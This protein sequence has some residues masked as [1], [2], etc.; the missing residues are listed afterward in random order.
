[1]LP[2]E[3]WLTLLRCNVK[4]T[5]DR[6]NYHVRQLC[7]ELK[8]ANLPYRWN[9]VMLKRL[10]AIHEKNVEQLEA[11]ATNAWN[12]A[13]PEINFPTETKGRERSDAHVMSIGDDF[14]TTLDTMSLE[15]EPPSSVPD[16]N[17]S[18]TA[19]E[20]DITSREVEITHSPRTWDRA[21]LHVTLQHRRR[22]KKKK[23]PKAKI[24]WQRSRGKQTKILSDYIQKFM[25]LDA[26]TR[27]SYESELD[28]GLMD[29]RL[30]DQQIFKIS[31]KLK[32]GGRRAGDQFHFVMDL[33]QRIPCKYFQASKDPGILALVRK[34]V[35][36]MLFHL[37]KK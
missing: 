12:A 32:Y 34:R 31:K 6:N 16:S 17:S 22:R 35:S 18:I 20:R 33:F 8:E 36:G 37:K 11:D 29:G 21:E 13:F 23:K 4:S 9:G 10:A 5:A 2:R 26:T 24:E 14:L 15:A 25:N 1:M 30:T 3:P 19:E 28:R 27:H 7:D